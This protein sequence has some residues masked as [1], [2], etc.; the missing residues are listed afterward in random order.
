MSTTS[1]RPTDPPRDRT[2]SATRVRLRMAASMMAA[3]ARSAALK[4]GLSATVAEKQAMRVAEAYLLGASNQARDTLRDAACRN[5]GAQ[6]A[7]RKTEGEG[8]VVAGEAALRALRRADPE[9]VGFTDS[10]QG[11]L[12]Q[13][14]AFARLSRLFGG[15]A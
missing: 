5:V 12:P 15:A 10:P 8:P 9:G 14:G 6:D 3:Q 4:D 1:T 7:M 2:M 13:P 11:E